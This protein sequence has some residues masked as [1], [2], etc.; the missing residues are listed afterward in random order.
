[1]TV[2]AWVEAFPLLGWGAGAP[3][4]LIVALIF[5][6]A[7]AGPVFDTLDSVQYLEL[8]IDGN[9]RQVPSHAA[10]VA[11][12]ALVLRLFPFFP[13]E[14]VLQ[15]LSIVAAAIS[16]AGVFQVVWY[17]TQRRS[18]AWLAALM[19]LVAGEFWYTATIIEVHALETALL[20]LALL[21]WLYAEPLDPRTGARRPPR[22]VIALS[23]LAVGLIGVATLVQPVSITVIVLVLFV[24]PLH[25]PRRVMLGA[26]ALAVTG[27]ALGIVLAGDVLLQGR[28]IA[29][30]LYTFVRNYA[31]LVLSLNL[32]LVVGAGLLW[33][34]RLRVPGDVARTRQLRLALLGLALVLIAQ[35][36][37]ALFVAGATHTSFALLAIA[38]GLLVGYAD[39]P[40]SRLRL[41]RGAL[42]L[43][44]GAVALA[45]ILVLALWQIAPGSVSGVVDHIATRLEGRVGTVGL[46]GGAAAVLL[47]VVI[48]AWAA[49]RRQPDVPFDPRFVLRGGAIVLFSLVL[50][51]ATIIGPRYALLRERSQAVA[52]LV[53]LSPPDQAIVG[54]P[55]ELM[56]YDHLHPE[57]VLFEPQH[58][59]TEYLSPAAFEA[60]LARF[61]VLYLVGPRTREEVASA[62]IDL[63][64][65][66]VTQPEPG[67]AIWV[68]RAASD[69]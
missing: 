45:L 3:A 37:F 19:L 54:G 55:N 13:A 23:A 27:G 21:A 44:A 7:T 50:G 62:G 57:R 68:V 4:V 38:Y 42:G 61:G 32:A 48:G 65:Y 51:A 58:L 52:R 16:V 34:D 12:G 25:L 69:S 18:A 30:D 36:P 60:A 29:L 41:L 1:M 9:L 14:R 11:V 59:D 17:R 56:L 66:T 6:A 28:E 2:R 5:L 49:S 40:A 64:D 46:V 20:L 8:A 47:A 10:Y 63:A 33:T 26:V 22:T 39:I 31:V 35:M 67:L 15:G 24:R 43:G 53:Q